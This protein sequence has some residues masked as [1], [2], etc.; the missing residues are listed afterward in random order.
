MPAAA[1]WQG[2]AEILTKKTLDRSEKSQSA[3][4][5]NPA[6]IFLSFAQVF[7]RDELARSEE[8]LPHC[9]DIR[10]FVRGEIRSDSGGC[11]VSSFP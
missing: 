7:E 1:L 8:F 10:I 4:G 11:T 2:R 6:N 5:S 3:I 9:P